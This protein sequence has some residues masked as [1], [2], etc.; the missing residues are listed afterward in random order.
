M[1]T[2]TTKDIQII[3]ALLAKL[4][5]Q[6]GITM[7]SEEMKHYKRSLVETYS[8]GREESTKGLYVDEAGQLKQD[9]QY[10]VN[11][12]NNTD[13]RKRS[14]IEVQKNQKRRLLLAYAHEMMWELPGGKVD[15][16]RVNNWCVKYGQY[17]KE[18]NAHSL[19]ELSDIIVQMEKAYRHLLRSV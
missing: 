17:H 6:M 18:L 13:Q 12:H 14:P 3:H 16:E 19:T 11:G 4:A 1:K 15:M 10:L 8:N 2:A 5:P 9:L 7:G